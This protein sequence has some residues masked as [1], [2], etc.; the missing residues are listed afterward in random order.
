MNPPT[1]IVTGASYG[2]GA[3]IAAIAARQGAQVGLTAR[4]Q[5]ALEALARQIEQEGGRALVVAGDISKYEDCQRIIE[6]T[7]QAF[8]K[9]DAL[10]NNAAVIEPFDKVVDV[11]L[12]EWNQVM[13]V[14]VLGPLMMCKQSIPHLRKTQGHIVN[15][16]SGVADMAIL[17]TSAYASS[18]AALNC[19]SKI[20]AVEEPELTVLIVNPGAMDTPMQ[21]VVREKSKGKTS[22]EIYKFFID[23]YAQGNLIPPGKS[24]LLIVNLVLK[25][26]HA[27]SGEILE[28]NDPRLQE[29]NP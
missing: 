25:A 18:K 24:A 23:L 22:D 14:N 11:Q 6:Q 7:V 12:A 5:P 15:V 29:L 8:G 28:W 9:I 27:W 16:S 2:L 20:L 4:S 21:A 17:A 10:V 1:I 13:A 19:F 3:A 26:P